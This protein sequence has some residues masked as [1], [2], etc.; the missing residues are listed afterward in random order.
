MS[1]QHYTWFNKLPAWL[2][3]APQFQADAEKLLLAIGLAG[4]LV[5]AARRASAPILAAGSNLSNLLVPQSR[6]SLFG[7]FD[8]LIEGFIKYQDSILGKE[9]RRYL[10]FTGT[11]FV[12]IL[13]ANMLGLVPGFAAITTTIWV[14]VAIAFV[15]FFYFNWQGIKAHGAIGYLKHFAGPIWWLAWLIFPVEIF[16]TCVR[17]LTLNL[18]LYWNITADHIVLG[19][20]TEMTKL[21]VPVVFYGLGTFVSLVQAFIFTTLTMIYILLATQHEEEGGHH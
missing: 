13:A 2:E 12:F 11:I 7:F 9:N 16:S 18:R 3:I 15:V 10:P 6:L 14:N 1:A 21:I 8:L 5:F 19:T 17:I 20:F 4:V